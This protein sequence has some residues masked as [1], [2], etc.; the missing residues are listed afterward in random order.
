MFSS[1]QLHVMSIIQP[2]HV[3]RTL[4]Q[5]FHCS[6]ALEFWSARAK[7]AIHDSVIPFACYSTIKKV[8][9][10]PLGTGKIHVA[11]MTVVIL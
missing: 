10:P 1:F 9:T 5:E 8:E 7:W 4:L 6:L 2:C 11:N 3:Q